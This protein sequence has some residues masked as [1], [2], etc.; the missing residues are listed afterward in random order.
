MRAD[1]FTRELQREH[2]I[3]VSDL[4]YP[5]FVMEGQAQREPMFFQCLVLNV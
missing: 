3:H 1:D 2:R 4:I 5:V